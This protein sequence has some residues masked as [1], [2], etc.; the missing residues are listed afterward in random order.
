MRH[1]FFL[2]ETMNS[3]ARNPF[4]SFAAMASVLVTLMV[5]GVFIPIVQAT[6][7]AAKEVRNR[8]PVNVVLKPD[9]T[10]EQ[11]AAVKQKINRVDGIKNVV[12]V[13]KAQAYK[14]EREKYPK[15]YALMGSNPRGDT[16]RI[17]SQDPDDAPK[18][19]S[20]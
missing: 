15:L 1:T 3:I 10:A 12:F 6:T 19:A 14:T 13:T 2:R 20:A 11:V 7:G 5:L 18:I 4:P 9:V 8:A 16:Y 17:T